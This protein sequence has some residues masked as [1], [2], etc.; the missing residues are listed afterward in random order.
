MKHKRYALIRTK[1]NLL[2]TRKIQP[3]GIFVQP[4][5]RKRKVGRCKLCSLKFLS[6]HKFHKHIRNHVSQPI[7]RLQKIRWPIVVKINKDRW[8]LK[9]NEVFDSHNN[10]GEPP[11]DCLKVT[12]RKK[13]DDERS[14]DSSGKACPLKLT[15]KINKKK[16]SA[17]A[18]EFSVVSTP[19]PPSDISLGL[20]EHTEDSFE[21][22]ASS[23][24]TDQCVSENGLTSMSEE[25]EQMAD[26][27]F[28]SN[29]ENSDANRTTESDVG[30]DQQE[31]E[32]NGDEEPDLEMS[33]QDDTD[34]PPEDL[35]KKLILKLTSKKE[36][37]DPEEQEEQEQE[38][39]E[40]KEDSFCEEEEMSFKNGIVKQTL[41][42]MKN[43]DLEDEKQYN[44]KDSITS[45]SEEDALKEGDRDNMEENGSSRRNS[46]NS[47]EGTVSPAPSEGGEK[48]VE[49]KS[50]PESAPTPTPEKREG[51]G[52]LRVRSSSEMMKSASEFDMK[53]PELHAESTDSFMSSM[54]D[55]QTGAPVPSSPGLTVLSAAQ[56]GATENSSCDS[57]NL[58]QNMEYQNQLASG[59]NYPIQPEGT[60][61]MSI[62]QLGAGDM[63]Y[64]CNLGPEC[65]GMMF[66]SAADLSAHQAST[67]NMV[68]PVQQ[69]AQ[70]VQRMPVPQQQPG[71]P[72]QG[73]QYSMRG[74]SPQF[75]QSMPPHGG[76]LAPKQSMGGPRYPTGPPGRFPQPIRQRMQMSPVNGRGQPMVG[77]GGVVKRPGPPLGR[78]GT[79]IPQ[80]RRYDTL[81]PSRLEDNDCHVIAMQKR[82]NDAGLVIQNVQGRDNN[83]FQLS[84]AITLSLRNQQPK[85]NPTKSVA[86][87]LASRGITVTPSGGGSKAP[88]SPRRN[89]PTEAALNSLNHNSAISII[90]TNSNNNSGK[91]AGN[92]GFAVPQGIRRTNITERPPRPPTVDLTGN[93]PPQRL[94]RGGA[95]Y[96]CQVCDKTYSSPDLLNQHMQSHRTNQQTKIP[97]RCN[98]CNAQYPNQQSL[99]QHKKS[100]HRDTGGTEMALPVV[101]L[102]Q[103]GTLSRL[104]QLGVKF[105]IP[106]SQLGNQSGGGVFG[107]PVIS[108]DGA[109]NPAVCNLGALG[110]SNILSLG[111]IKSLG[112]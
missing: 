30:M 10:Y 65:S 29:E 90:S 112:R 31:S 105:C 77:R 109:K 67:H 40:S 53:D 8:N 19:S 13:S 75:R 15:L 21:R 16:N 1:K 7:V 11:T 110:A 103:P 50:E 46:F 22:L 104:Q 62:D 108:I 74:M 4:T 98:L 27:N 5:A 79:P 26:D 41:E 82:N 12:E 45:E 6:K 25:E 33:A 111:P 3:S 17:G 64:R 48:S 94:G 39:N 56:L 37:L 88:I 57:D 106:L 42:D 35:D 47:A 68:P 51:G 85:E 14:N 49:S 24:M 72:P 93:D 96:T 80:K 89:S 70:Q 2:M 36:F 76:L 86:N 52:L 91:Q 95:Q 78:G 20:R 81:M 61:Y 9:E 100:H 44:H 55:D 73:P 28:S 99:L 71:M 101:D 107:L 32:V 84:D 23:N 34:D 59:Y 18:P 38:L 63:N 58:L 43:G 60:E 69:L 66:M 83:L 92:T 102:K 87:V 97:Y 54:S